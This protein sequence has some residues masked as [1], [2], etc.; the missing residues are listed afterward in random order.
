MDEEQR[1]EF[2]KFWKDLDDGFQIYYTYKDNRYLIYKI[3]KNCYKRELITKKEKS[4][5]QINAV[6]TLKTVRE[7]FKEMEDIE[8]KIGISD[9]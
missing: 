6:L 9:E 3:T 1:H 2:N 7:L 4:A 8:Y 5:N